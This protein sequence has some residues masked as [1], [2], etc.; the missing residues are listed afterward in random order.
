MAHKITLLVDDDDD[1]MVVTRRKVKLSLTKKNR[2]K[3]IT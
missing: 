1:V 3:E 2:L